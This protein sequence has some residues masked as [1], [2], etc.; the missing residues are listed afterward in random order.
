VGN[1]PK[2]SYPG[3]YVQE[4]PSGDRSVSGVSTSI[5]AFVGY[6]ARGKLGE[7]T[8]IQSYADFEKTFGGLHIQSELSYAIRQYFLNGGTDAVVI[9]TASGAKAAS[10][11]LMDTVGAGAKETLEVTA[12][13]EGVW[14]NGL[15][16]TV[17]Y[18][19]SNPDSFFNLTVGVYKEGA[20]SP[21]NQEVFRNLSMN[22][23]SSSYA[24]TVINASSK[25][26]RVASLGV[27]TAIAAD[28]KG[29][30]TS[31]E[32]VLNA[33]NK[34]AL[35]DGARKIRV[36]INGEG[37]YEVALFPTGTTALTAAELAT[38]M[39]AAINAASG[40]DNFK[41]ATVQALDANTIRIL[42]GVGGS[43]S[44]VVVT[45][46]AT[47]DASKLLK[48]GLAA[49]GREVEAAAVARPAQN[50]TASGEL[51]LGALT[52]TETMKTTVT[53]KS[54]SVTLLTQSIGLGWVPTTLAQLAAALQ[55]Q[56]RA[57]DPTNPRLKGLTVKAVGNRLVVLTSA[58]SGDTVLTFADGT[59]ETLGAA[60][61]LNQANVQWY[62]LG[63]PVSLGAQ[64]AGN[65]G[66]DGTPAATAAELLGSEAA[67]TGLYA[68]ENTDLFNLL[69]IPEMAKLAK[70]GNLTAY[71][72]VLSEAMAYAERRRAFM[73][74]DAP[75]T[76]DSREA[77]EEWISEAPRHKNAAV[78]WPQIMV[79][80]PL[81][82]YRLRAIAPSGTV[83]GVFARTDSSRGIWKVPAGVDAT[84]AGVQALACNLTDAE[85]GILN[86]LGVNCLR[87]FPVY[88]KVIWGART[89]AGADEM[90]S[91]W[92]YVA[93]RRTSL[94][95][96]ES[97]FRG[98]KWA[99]FEPNSENLWAQIRL[100]VGGFM[101][102][103]Y[104]QGA[105]PGSP[106][107]AYFVQCDAATTTAEDVNQGV[108]NIMVGFAPL[109]PAE[110]VVLNLQ[111]IAQAQG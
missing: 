33:D 42:A 26:I 96:E 97:L 39:T 102:Q 77:M 74:V 48:L 106:K 110:F 64:H 23:S 36:S 1:V 61:Q 50:G 2:F 108:V 14:G 67:K 57:I 60:L 76:V 17:D 24:P 43:A 10:V 27:E 83:A 45:P 18:A 37:P 38:A 7:A 81:N 69:C 79:A 111:Q 88:G 99:V 65:P 3:V 55:A 91:E 53:L 86:Q 84:M 40:T 109:K 58:D 29:F 85:N 101:N 44:S 72:Q 46:A 35:N 94:Y 6:T 30:S 54:G 4:I 63:A 21:I 25:L 92:K 8:R 13:S 12:A 93:V 47:S 34:I 75:A 100:S 78:Y 32:L 80:D 68:L 89:L 5:T 73:L 31:G 71:T 82:G 87:N 52:L 9:R 104:R 105:F 56:L 107:D 51:D 66:D 49:G 70:P 16:V 59:G 19:T 103:L 28:V 90:V 62:S 22:P 95:I 20:A 98:T 11:K 41:N 15:R